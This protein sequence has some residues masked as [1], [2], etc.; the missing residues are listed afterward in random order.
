MPEKFIVPRSKNYPYKEEYTTTSLRLPVA[1][2]HGYDE[3]AAK[4]IYSRNK[5]MC[6]ALEYAMQNLAFLS[7]E[8]AEP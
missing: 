3:L 6:M 1:L 4:S 2:L 5:L 7:D 8:D